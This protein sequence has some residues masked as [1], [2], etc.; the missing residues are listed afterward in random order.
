MGPGGADC[1]ERVLMAWA[2]TPPLHE[3]RDLK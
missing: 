1:S 3:L 2:G